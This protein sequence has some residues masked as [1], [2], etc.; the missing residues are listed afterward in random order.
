MNVRVA[1]AIMVASLAG[2]FAFV[3]GEFDQ[4]MAAQFWQVARGE[5]PVIQLLA[6]L[7]GYIAILSLLLL[8][9]LP[10][11]RKIVGSASLNRTV[12][13]KLFGDGAM[14]SENAIRDMAG[15]TSGEL[16]RI[17]GRNKESYTY[18]EYLYVRKYVKRNSSIRDLRKSGVEKHLALKRSETD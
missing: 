11:F 13:D 2:A 1:V 8:G 6:S 17:F 9:L 18:V 5:D 10:A 3:F 4:G 16:V 15:I 7:A 14:V 12:R